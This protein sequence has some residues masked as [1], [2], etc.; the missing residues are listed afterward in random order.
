MQRVLDQVT[1][2]SAA[3]QDTLRAET[4]TE[5]AAIFDSL[6]SLA[7]AQADERVWA[8]TVSRIRALSHRSQASQD[9]D[10]QLVAATAAQQAETGCVPAAAVRLNLL[11]LITTIDPRQAA[12][13]CAYSLDLVLAVKPEE[14][15]E[16]MRQTAATLRASPPARELDDE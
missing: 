6:C 7:K 10:T 13:W 1:V 14:W 12:S 2:W 3:S 5:T 9:W 11:P 4:E 16:G 15:T 8:P